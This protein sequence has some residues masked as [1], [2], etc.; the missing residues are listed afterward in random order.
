MCRDRASVVAD[1]DGIFRSRQGVRQG[2]AELVVG[3]LSGGVARHAD[4][5][6]DR[7]VEPTKAGLVGRQGVDAAAGIMLAVEGMI[8]LEYKRRDLSG[9]LVLRLDR[10]ADRGLAGGDLSATH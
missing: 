6:D 8:V 7:D 9:F 1:V 10:Y 2:L 3:Q 4:Q 5:V